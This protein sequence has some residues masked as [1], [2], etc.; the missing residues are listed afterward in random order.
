MF[1]F[2]SCAFWTFVYHLRKTVQSGPLF[3]F[4]LGCHQSEQQKEKRIQKNEDSVSSLWDNFKCSNIHIRGVPEGEEKEQGI[5]NLFEKI[6]K[7]NFP[8]LVKKVDIQLCSGS[9]E[10]PGKDGCKEAHSKT[11]HS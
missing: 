1:S 7:E 11:Q 5:G 10:S 6:I 9:T 3:L 8:N 4:Q 2:F